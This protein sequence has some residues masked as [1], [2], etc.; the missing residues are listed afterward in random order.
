MACI[1]IMMMICDTEEEYYKMN[2]KMICY[3]EVERDFKTVSY[4]VF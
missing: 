3:R 1:T 4:I 2:K